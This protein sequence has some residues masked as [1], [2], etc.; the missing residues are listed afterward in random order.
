MIIENGSLYRNLK[1]G[2]IYIVLDKIINKTSDDE[3]ILY[4]ELSKD[5]L[6]VRDIDD[7]LCKF[8]KIHNT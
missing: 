1:N 2:K 6:Y 4:K 7:F 8:N 5:T 3:V